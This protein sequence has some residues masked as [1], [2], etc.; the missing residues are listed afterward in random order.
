MVRGVPRGSGVPLSVLVL[1]VALSLVALLVVS[2]ACVRIV[3]AVA[4]N[5][6]TFTKATSVSGTGSL[7]S[8]LIRLM[9]SRRA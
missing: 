1:V 2:V 5:M 3:M 4:I 7:I 6:L 8:S 9:T